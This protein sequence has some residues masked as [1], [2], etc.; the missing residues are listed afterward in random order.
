MLGRAPVAEHLHMLTLNI[1][2][3]VVEAAGYTWQRDGSYK[4]KRVVG[5]PWRR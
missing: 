5:M 1:N 3:K 2:G 4:L